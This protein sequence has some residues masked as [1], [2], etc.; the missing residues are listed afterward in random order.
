MLL[1]F[2]P[3]SPRPIRD[4]NLRSCSF[5]TLYIYIHTHTHTT[6]YKK[7]NGSEHGKLYII[8]YLN[9]ELMRLLINY[10]NGIVYLKRNKKSFQGEISKKNCYKFISGF[11]D[12]LDYH[13]FSFK[14]R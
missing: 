4:S 7:D 6:Y 9:I 3:H 1:I 12:N 10:S 5:D 2:N 8:S 13:L 11:I 14:F